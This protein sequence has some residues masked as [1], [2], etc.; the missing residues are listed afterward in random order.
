MNLRSISLGSTFRIFF[1][2][3]GGKSKCRDEVDLI[4]Q[5]I[6]APKNLNISSWVGERED[7]LGIKHSR[8]W[9]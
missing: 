3:M 6:I 7:G 1:Q 4:L 2:K 5:P 8:Y 9:P